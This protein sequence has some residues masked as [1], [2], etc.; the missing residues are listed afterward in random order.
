MRVQERKTTLF[1]GLGE[2]AS[3]E[4]TQSRARRQILEFKNKFQRFKISK[5]QSFKGSNQH[6]A[7]ANLE[8]ETLKPGS[9]SGNFSGSSRQ[10][11]QQLADGQTRLQQQNHLVCIDSYLRAHRD[12]F[13]DRALQCFFLRNSER[14]G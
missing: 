10:I 6:L 14:L 13:G 7:L 5:V 12:N 8:I 9:A 1:P 3:L 2:L 4:T 11:F